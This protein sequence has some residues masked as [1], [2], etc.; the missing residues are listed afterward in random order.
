MDYQTNSGRRK[1]IQLA[2]KYTN[3][4]PR[5][6]WTGLF[7]NIKIDFQSDLQI[8]FFKETNP[9]AKMQKTISSFG[10]QP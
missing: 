8:V 9:K 2:A 7:I 3:K 6:M 4:Q 1:D 5:S 10:L